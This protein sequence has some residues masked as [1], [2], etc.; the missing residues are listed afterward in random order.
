MPTFKGWRHLFA[1]DFGAKPAITFQLA[2]VFIKTENPRHGNCWGF[3]TS[4]N[5]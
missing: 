1:Y 5:P 3:A 2:L 4:A